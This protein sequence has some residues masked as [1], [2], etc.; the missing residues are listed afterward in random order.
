METEKKLY[1]LIENNRELSIY[2][3]DLNQCQTLMQLD[4]D[5]LC[6]EDISDTQY[7]ITPTYLTDEEISELPESDN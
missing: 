6:A 3:S 4:I 7:T 1:Y 5:S 2:V